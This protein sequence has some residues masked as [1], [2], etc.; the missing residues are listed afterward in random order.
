MSTS[1]ILS[2]HDHPA[3]QARANE[4]ASGEPAV[5]GKLE[6]LFHFVRDDILFGFPPK[7]DAVKA[8]ETLAYGLGYCNTKAT[9]F[10]AL[11]KAAG[12]PARIHTGW[13]DIR[14]MRGIFPSFAFPFLPDAGGHSWTEIEIDGEWKPIDSYINDRPFYE[15]ALK[16]LAE[17]GK[18]TAFSISHA[19]GT[20]SCE[21]N[22]GEQGFVHMGAVVED[23]GTWPDFADYMASDRYWRMNL[24]QQMAYPLIASLANRNIARIRS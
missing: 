9:L 15:G 6:R 24:M 8:S 23:H 16:R 3:V 18:T 11:C 17:S 5:M 7:W 20:S 14:L 1:Q 10:L 19:R 12:I 4:L 13:I 2:D 22:F 21:F